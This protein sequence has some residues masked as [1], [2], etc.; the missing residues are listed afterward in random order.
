MSPRSSALLLASALLV[1]A[2][3]GAC[4]SDD[5][6]SSENSAAS[7]S[8]PDGAEGSSTLP[9]SS[10]GD[11][12]FVDCS[13]AEESVIALDVDS[14]GIGERGSG[15]FGLCAG[16]RDS[17]IISM[18]TDG[19]FATS[20]WGPDGVISQIDIADLDDGRTRV[21]TAKDIASWLDEPDTIA[22]DLEARDMYVIGFDR[23]AGQV[24]FLLRTP[25]IPTIQNVRVMTQDVESLLSSG[26]NP[27]LSERILA[28]HFSFRWSPEGT[29]CASR[30]ERGDRGVLDLSGSVYFYESGAPVYEV[31]VSDSS[32]RLPLD[33]VVGDFVWGDEETIYFARDGGIQRGLMSG[34]CARIYLD[35]GARPNNLL[36]A[37]GGKPLVWTLTQ[38]ASKIVVSS[39]ESDAS[40]TNVTEL[41]AALEIVEV[42]VSA[43]PSGPKPN[44]FW[45]LLDQ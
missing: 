19:R 3:L 41:S 20:F 14:G 29:R 37:A 11:V 27:V 42:D 45:H 25:G 4:T 32:A 8:A 16:D 38:D 39:I 22:A 15:D 34:E 9:A 13:S 36:G 2:V 12:Y 35:S 40:L 44:I 30:V 7:T 6:S 5:N 10:N 18:T 28:C 33:C 31:G 17:S 21:V 24:F 1:P 23:T 26:L 43:Q